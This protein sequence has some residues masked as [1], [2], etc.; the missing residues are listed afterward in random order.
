MFELTLAKLDGGEIIPIKYIADQITREEIK[1]Y[2][3]K[4]ELIQ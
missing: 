3:I 1:E 2:R 4:A